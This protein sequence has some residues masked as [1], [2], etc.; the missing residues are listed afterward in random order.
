[1]HT[2][3]HRTFCL[4]LPAAIAVI[5][6]RELHDPS[7][8]DSFTA[9]FPDRMMTDQPNHKSEVYTESVLMNIYEP[10]VRFDADMRLTPCLAESWDNPTTLVWRFH[11]R[12]GVRFHD[13]SELTAEDVRHSIE[14]TRDSQQ[15]DF[16]KPLRHIKSVAV[17][18]RY[19]VDLTADAPYNVPNSLV[20]V[21]ILHTG[22]SGSAA[23]TG[24]Y[25]QVEWV[26]GQ[27]M[28]M[29]AFANYWRGKPAIASV[30][31]LFP[32][33]ADARI[34]L[35]LSGQV[36]LARDLPVGRLTEI[37]NSP[38]CNLIVRRGINVAY[39]AFDVERESSP[40]V[41]GKN[42]FRDQ[43]V[44]EA[45]AL[46]VDRSA[47]VD[48][49]LHGFASEAWQIFP[50]DIFGHTPRLHAPARDIARAKDLLAQA[51][52]PNGFRTRLDVG[53]NRVAMAH[54]IAQQLAECG[55][56]VEVAI[57]PG[58]KL[59]RLLEK[60]G[61][62]FYLVG[63]SCDTGDGQD[64]LE[65]CFHVPSGPDEHWLGNAGHYSNQEVS[66]LLQALSAKTDQRERLQLLG[67]AAEIIGRD[68]P[69]VP[70]VIE[71]DTY[72]ISKRFDF[73]PRADALLDLFSVRPAAKGK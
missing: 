57:Y 12:R 3:A 70:L 44:R 40:G 33:D 61:S 49:T 14:S 51:G 45:V 32:G 30:H 21:K 73:K 11:L 63:W 24:S 8:A 6:C 50:P 43:R 72:G 71:H 48:E 36:D 27:S 53:D 39:L 15:S 58:D 23:G 16:A 54:S 5:G 62:S 64:V 1:M 47:I 68:F 38:N 41:V 34:G 52:Y 17:V 4:I 37:R 56:A 59:I 20:F 60:S 9:A 67:A 19:T 35:L 25:E 66:T 46:A 10:L 2:R 7:R 42:P 69:W 31:L 13:G 65:F 26:P 28:R 18:D 55:V 22:S 29:Q